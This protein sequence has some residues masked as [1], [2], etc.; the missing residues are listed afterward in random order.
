M[1]IPR[2]N[3]PSHPFNIHTRGSVQKSSS[4]KAAASFARGAYWHYVSTEN[5]RERRWWIFSTDPLSKIEWTRD[6]NNQVNIT[7]S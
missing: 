6:E 2:A 1:Q 5:W 4:S 3:Y 7:H